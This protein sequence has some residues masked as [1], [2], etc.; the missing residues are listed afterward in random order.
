MNAPIN[1]VDA[2]ASEQSLGDLFR[3]LSRDVTELLR[4]EV[5]L[6]RTEIGDE[7]AKAGR[8]G[9]VLGAAG[10]LAVLSLTFLSL[11]AALALDEVMERPVAFLIVGGAYV[12][13]A[14]IFG[15]VGRSMIKSVR[16]MPEETVETLKE[17]AQW[18][19]AQ[20]T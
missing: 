17:D 1:G 14:L 9:G 10:A 5:E 18:A 12:V 13:L 16:P 19:K 11:A 8:A 20:L 7:A 6:A 15:L 3:S 2:P 4:K